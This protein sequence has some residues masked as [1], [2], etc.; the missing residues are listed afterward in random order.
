MWVQH[1]QKMKSDL[2]FFKAAVA[3]VFNNEC[4]YA[5]LAWRMIVFRPGHCCQMRKM[6]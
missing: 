4:E 5:Y 3:T 2:F 6:T 1:E